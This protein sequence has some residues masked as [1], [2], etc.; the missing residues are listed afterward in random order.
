MTDLVYKPYQPEGVLITTAANREMISSVSGLERAM[1]TGRTLEARAMLCDS[2]QNLIIDLNGMK[3]V[4]PRDDVAIGAV[5]DGQVRD[6]AIIT[7]VGKPVCFKVTGLEYDEQ[8]HPIALLSRRAAQEEVLRRYILNLTP[9]DIIDAKITH[10][11]PFGCFVDIGCGVIS[12]LTIDSISVSRISHPSDRFAI[13]QFIKVIVKAVDAE[14]QK[15]TLTHKE[16]LGTW[17]ENARGFK[18]G[19]TTA[20][21]VRSVEPYGIFIEL[22]PNLAGLAEYKSGVTAGQSAAVYIKNIIPERMKIKLVLIDTYPADTA[23]PRLHYFVTGDHIDRW[24]FSPEY[25]D[26]QVVTTFDTY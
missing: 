19:Q 2:A 16:L 5:S 15:I 1:L 6:I 22:T 10:F 26:K 8:G 4:I 21:I 13:G 20:G 17:E 24:Q 7:R 25:C 3:G 14:G 9:G 12:L 18:A 23:P 11:E